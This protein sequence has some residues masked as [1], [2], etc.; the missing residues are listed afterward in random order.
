MVPPSKLPSRLTA[1][2]RTSP[3]WWWTSIPL[4]K[5]GQTIPPPSPPVSHRKN[6]SRT[7]AVSSFWINAILNGL[8]AFFSYRTRGNIPYGEAAVDIL[9]T[10]FIITFLTAWITVGLARNEVIKGNLTRLATAR[11]GLKLPTS[12]ALRALLIALACT[13]LFGGLFLDGLLYLVSP[14]EMSNWAYILLKTLYAG[15][16]GALA[17]ALTILSVVLDENRS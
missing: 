2:T 7:Q 15:A 11:R 8:I 14:S 13:L 3:C 16:S 4:R 9:I 5:V 17:S 6:T 1:P 10:V 12:P